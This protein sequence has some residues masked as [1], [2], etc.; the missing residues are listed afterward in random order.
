VQDGKGRITGA[1]KLYVSSDADNLDCIIVPVTLA[2]I[3]TKCHPDG[4]DSAK[5]HAGEVCTEDSHRKRRGGICVIKIPPGQYRG[6]PGS[7]RIG[8]VEAEIS[9]RSSLGSSWP[10]GPAGAASG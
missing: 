8:R 5:Q 2:I 4:I 1:A 9:A 10:K 7:E 6:P 3:L